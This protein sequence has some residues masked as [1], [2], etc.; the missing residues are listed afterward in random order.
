[1]GISAVMMGRSSGDR[2]RCARDAAIC[3]L[4]DIPI[5]SRE[6]LSWLELAAARIPCRGFMKIKL[7]LLTPRGTHGIL[8]SHVAQRK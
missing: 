6:L 1:M 2:P 4:M 3:L 7:N 8:H 5:D